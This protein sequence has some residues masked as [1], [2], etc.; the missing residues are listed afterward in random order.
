MAGLSPIP[1]CYKTGKGGM[2]AIACGL[3]CTAH[4]ASNHAEGKVISK[5][6]EAMLAHIASPEPKGAQAL[7]PRPQHFLWS[8]YKVPTHENTRCYQHL[9]Y[10]SRNQFPE[11]RWRLCYP[12]FIQHLLE[13]SFYSPFLSP[14]SPWSRGRGSN[15]PNGRW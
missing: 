11:S 5:T 9:K 12:N 4:A 14:C 13:Q 2:R 15:S 3:V 8:R 7:T 10:Q 1:L 6:G